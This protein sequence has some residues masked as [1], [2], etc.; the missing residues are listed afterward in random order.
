MSSSLSPDQRKALIRHYLEAAWNTRKAEE[1][2]NAPTCIAL[3]ESNQ[4]SEFPWREEVNTPACVY[5]GAECLPMSLEQAR[6]MLHASFPDL[7]LTVIDLVVEEEKVVVR[8]LMQGTDLGGCEGRLPTGRSIRLTGITLMLMEG[9]RIVE[10]WNEVDIAG[11]LRQ[12][13]FVYVP[14]PPRITMR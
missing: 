8:W 9:C 11:M 10:E 6:Q 7:H 2:T 3:Q 5:L 14:Q 4:Q 1:R 12:L 13:G